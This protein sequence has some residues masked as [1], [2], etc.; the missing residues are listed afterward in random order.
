[1]LFV[2]SAGAEAAAMDD[3]AQFSVDE[4]NA[5]LKGGSARPNLNW[6]VRSVHRCFGRSTMAALHVSE[7][8]PFFI[9]TQAHGFLL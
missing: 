2:L 8:G 9:S 6:C 5:L 7:M 4:I 3:D 1:M